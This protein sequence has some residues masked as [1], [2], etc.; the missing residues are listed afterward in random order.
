METI[1]LSITKEEVTA[2]R[3]SLQ[4]F[5]DHH[6]NLIGNKDKELL[7]KNIPLPTD[8]DLLAGNLDIAI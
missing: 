7:E 5:Q 4:F 2:I 1:N 3:M 6:A 8:Q